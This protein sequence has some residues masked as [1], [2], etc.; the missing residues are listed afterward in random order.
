V[1]MTNAVANWCLNDETDFNVTIPFSAT[2][3]FWL[4]TTQ[5]SSSESSDVRSK[6]L[7]LRRY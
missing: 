4:A 6:V 1:R 5:E 2:G 3:F 7:F